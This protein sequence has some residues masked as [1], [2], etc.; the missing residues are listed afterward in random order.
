MG[1]AGY[2]LGESIASA[3]HRDHRTGR[4][5]DVGHLDSSPDRSHSSHSGAVAPSPGT[6]R[7]TVG[8]EEEFLLVDRASD[9]GGQGARRH[10]RGGAISGRPSGAGVLHPPRWEVHTDPVVDLANLRTQLAWLRREVAAA[11]ATHDCLLLAVGSPVIPPKHPFT[12][13]PDPRYEAMAARYAA[14]LGDRDQAVNG[15]H[16]HVC[17]APGARHWPSPTGYGPGCPCCR[18]L[19]PTPP[20]TA[21]RTPVTP[22]GARSNTPE[23]P[24]SGPLPFST[25]PITNTS[26]PLSC[27]PARSW[28]AG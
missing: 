11:A 18:P 24:R 14:V 21:A 22:A 12:V 5:E 25:K 9:S 10:C 16:I 1:R 8:V 13:T 26:P 28:I 17:V 6:G 23:G 7:L 27:A 4:P 15:C 3:S 19:A 20:T 2:E